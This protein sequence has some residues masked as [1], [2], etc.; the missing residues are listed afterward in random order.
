[1]INSHGTIVNW[2]MLP[3]IDNF[4][5]IEWGELTSVR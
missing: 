3:D 5:C 1:M 4:C 2:E